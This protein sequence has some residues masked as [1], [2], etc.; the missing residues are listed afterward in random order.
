MTEEQK[1]HLENHTSLDDWKKRNAF[2]KTLLSYAS[3]A[4]AINLVSSSYGTLYFFFYDDA[5][6]KKIEAYDTI[7]EPLL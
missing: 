7:Q 6:N 2:W 5:Y 3:G 4:F 1:L